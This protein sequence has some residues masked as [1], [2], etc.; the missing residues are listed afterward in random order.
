MLSSD[1]AARYHEDG[2][3]IPDF[4]LGAEALEEIRALHAALL[5]RHP[6]FGDYCS[7]LLDYEPAFRKFAE[8][9]EILDMVGQLIG[10]DIA[11]WNMSFFAK[12]AHGGKRT[13]W[14]QDG[15]YWPIRPL[16]TC[17]VWLAVDEA[18]KENGCLKF[19]RGSHKDQRLK[20]HNRTEATDVTLNQE[21][22]PSAYDECAA[23]D[24]VLKPGQ[25]SLH[26][27]YLLHGSEANH[28]DKPRR[29]M[30][31]RFMPTTSLFDREL[32]K[33][34]SESQKIRDQSGQKVFL[35]RGEDRTGRNRFEN[36]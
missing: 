14:H 34:K 17:T 30:T 11:L 4:R 18:T 33:R 3:V 27:V 15:E 1:Q 2:Y 28:S 20:A 36:A 25:I 22:D 32:A 12:P 16:A 9:P 24:L 21:L 31:M 6:E 23:V 19:I 13:P 7:A 29:G 26:D 35:M 5:Q 10:P 8:R